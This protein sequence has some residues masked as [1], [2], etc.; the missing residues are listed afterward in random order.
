MMQRSVLELPPVIAP[1]RARE[2]LAG[3]RNWYVVAAAADSERQL[4]HRDDIHPK[5]E[6]ALIDADE[7]GIDLL[8]LAADP[9][10]VAELHIQAT[11]REALTLM[12]VAEVDA[13]YVSG[14]IA[15][16]HPDSGVVT[17]NDI[18]QYYRAPSTH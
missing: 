10:P 7:S 11:L 5:L 3:D 15:G 4:I 17:R 6:A 1:D 8:D 2:L 12:E 16:P 14:Y 13:L 18:E 9:R